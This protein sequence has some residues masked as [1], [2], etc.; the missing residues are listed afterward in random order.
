MADHPTR[1]GPDHPRVDDFF[2]ENPDPVPGQERAEPARSR[3]AG[4]DGSDGRAEDAGPGGEDGPGREDGPGKDGGE[5]LPDP[6]GAGSRGRRAAVGRWA[7]AVAA[8]GVAGV[9]VYGAASD[10]VSGV[11]L[12]A[13][14]DRS[15]PPPTTE[16]QQAGV[17]VVTGSALGCVGPDLVGLDDPT[18]AEPD[19]TV[20]VAAGAAPLEVLGEAVVPAGAGQ[21]E[22]VA[23]PAGPTARAAVRDDIASVR[24]SG[25]TWA[26]GTASGALAPGF[27]GSQLGLGLE[28][29]QRG[30]STA[31]C[32]Q[33]ADEAW[34]VAGGGE[35][36]RA[37]RL[38]L[39]NPTGNPVTVNVEVLG[40]DGPVDVVGGRGIVIAPGA[41]QV[42]LLD[43]LAPGEERPV[44]HVTTTGGPV[45]AAVGDRWLEGTLD[46][47][48]ELT[49][50]TAAPA[51]TLLI[52][53]VPGPRADSADITSVR[54]AVPGAEQSVV[55]VRALTADGPVRVANAVTSVDAGSVADV[56]LSD[57]PE[58]TQAIEVVADTPVVA[59]AQ[60]VRRVEPEGVSELAWVPAVTPS[61]GV[62]GL[63]L[64]APGEDSVSLE[65]TVAS[66][67]GARVEVVTVT[68]DRT[69]VQ[70]VTIPAAGSRA[71]ELSRSTESIWVRPLRGSASSA[72][73][74]TVQ[75]E[76]GPLVAGM[77]LPEAPVT[78][79][80]RPVAPWAP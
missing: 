68:A 52:P 55:Q 3:R 36:G 76:L 50:P 80:V 59:S 40:A 54:V 66:V 79:Q 73:L 57:L 65:L 7:R 12:A 70:P 2:Y 24:L 39:A 6:T 9:L 21:I 69:H 34:F 62:V 22:L 75:D 67:E 64:A 16:G 11:D 27:A 20:S 4:D 44:A 13:A 31:P 61:T 17:A 74:T 37:E 47:G 53:A 23:A 28:E 38:I 18:V 33:A 72:L 49:T 63:P 42:V 56:D 25:A 26:R 71:L 29:Q 30:L 10:R 35:A 43:A 45:L 41:R 78:R 60:V 14:L 46:R 48:T 8:V 15:A 77:V 1:P 58:G 19:Q 32:G 5:E 51:T